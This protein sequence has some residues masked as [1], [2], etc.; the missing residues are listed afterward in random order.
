[1]NSPSLL[2]QQE[3]YILTMLANGCKR[4]ALGIHPE[5]VKTHLR[6]ARN[7]LNA[8]NLQHAIAIAA[9]DNHIEVSINRNQSTIASARDAYFTQ[10]SQVS[11]E[12][13][14]RFGNRS[15][16][17]QERIS[18]LKRKELEV[19]YFVT[20]RENLEYTNRMIARKMNISVNTLRQYLRRIYSALNLSSRAGLVSLRRDMEE[21]G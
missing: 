9:K 10:V 13:Q 2:T 11:S 19:F 7:K 12:S 4:S 18:R 1:M 16:T 3:T 14:N 17:V 5:T 20:S 15:K 6:N 21:E 8:V